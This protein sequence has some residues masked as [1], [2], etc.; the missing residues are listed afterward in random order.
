[1][2]KWSKYVTISC[3]VP[4]QYYPLTHYWIFYELHFHLHLT[5]SISIIVRYWKS[6]QDLYLTYSIAP[7]QFLHIVIAGTINFTTG[8][9]KNYYQLSIYSRKIKM[10]S[11]YRHI[12]VNELCFRQIS[13]ISFII[14]SFLHSYNNE[15]YFI[16][17]M[18][19]YNL[20][21][22]IGIDKPFTCCIQFSNMTSMMVSWH[23]HDLGDNGNMSF[24][25]FHI[26]K[27]SVNMLK[28]NNDINCW[29]VV[30]GKA[31]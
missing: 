24:L 18:M 30:P 26:I 16:S 22:C 27:I 15:C 19:K 25:Y 21:H 17:M 3:W 9:W 7:H 4:L 29:R 10:L 1:M 2:S 12:R 31:W 13:Q 23:E 11:I 8:W 20:S 28:I 14:S 6:L 5:F